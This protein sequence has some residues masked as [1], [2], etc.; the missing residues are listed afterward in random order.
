MAWTLSY[1]FNRPAFIFY[2]PVL[3]GLASGLPQCNLNV[4]SDLLCFHRILS[5]NKILN[6]GGKSAVFVQELPSVL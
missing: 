2:L 1:F 3:E 4:V 5:S 6:V